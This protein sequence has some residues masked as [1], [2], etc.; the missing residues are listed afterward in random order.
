MIEKKLKKKKNELFLFEKLHIRLLVECIGS[1][2]FNEVNYVFATTP[3]ISTTL[4]RATALTWEVTA[5][6]AF[7]QTVT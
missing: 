5:K 7:I 1:F 3:T 2:N 4:G 6:T